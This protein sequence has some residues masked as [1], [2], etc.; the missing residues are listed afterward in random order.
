[1]SEVTRILNGIEDSDAKAADGLL[2][3][4]DTAEAGNPLA[5]DDHEMLVLNRCAGWCTASRKT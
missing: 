3:Q 1:M 5:A 2:P 4:V